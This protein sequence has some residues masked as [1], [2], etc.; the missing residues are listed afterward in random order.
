MTDERQGNAGILTMVAI[1][2]LEHHPKNPRRDLGDLTELTESIRRSGV[3][4][5]LTAVPA[6][7]GGKFYVLLGNRRLEAARAAGLTE[8]PCRIVSDMPEAEQVAAM[9]A[10]N[11]Q[12]AN[13]TVLEQAEG[14][15]MMLDL[16]DDVAGVSDKTG[17]S[18]TTVRHRLKIAEL[19]I[20]ELRERERSGGFQLSMAEYED[21]EKV[22]DVDARRKILNAAMNA[23]D[24]H[25]RVAHILRDEAKK[26][27]REEWAAYLSGRGVEARPDA[28]R[29]RYLDTARWEGLFAID[30]EQHFDVEMQKLIEGRGRDASLAPLLGGDASDSGLFWTETW[31]GIEVIRERE[32][33]EREEDPEAAAR[34]KAIEDEQRL[35][36]L[37]EDT[38]E[39]VATWIESI[40]TR[41]M[42]RTG[43]SGDGAEELW[44]AL[45]ECQAMLSAQAA[46]EQAAAVFDGK[47]PRLS[48]EDNRA[49]R[50]KYGRLKLPYKMLLML[51]Y[52]VRR[53]PCVNWKNELVPGWVGAMAAVERALVA[54]RFE[55]PNEELARI[56]HGTHELFAKKG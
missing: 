24:L 50:E 4:Q 22:K 48:A 39:T 3:M 17:L 29:N 21:L 52:A 15:Q 14:M 7:A 16:G 36:E 10:E 5:N 28:A 20:D 9:L 44:E 27:M 8:V 42:A 37:V 56:A 12:R 13:L 55:W 26:K 6:E 30:L 40:V 45:T 53:L 34:A 38:K 46:V 2:E 25:Y 31:R 49:A 1:G 32:D 47:G 51:R 43:G 41:K 11:M 18:E 33:G 54:W 35:A 19:G 23:N